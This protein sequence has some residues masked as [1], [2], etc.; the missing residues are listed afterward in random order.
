MRRVLQLAQVLLLIGAGFVGLYI[1]RSVELGRRGAD[2]V[3]ID[4]VNPDGELIGP[5][6]LSFDS[7]GNLFVGDAAGRIW[8]RDVSGRMVQHTKIDRLEPPV[9]VHAAGLAFDPAGNLYVAVYDFAGGSILRIDPALNVRFFASDIGSANYLVISQNGRHL[10]VS[11]FRR[12]GRLLRFP[13]AAPPP[14]K[15][16]LIVEGF[17]YPNG[18]AFGKDENV[19]FAAETYSG[20]ITSMDL[21]RLRPQ[22]ETVLSLKG[23]FSLGS[24]DGLAFDPR[25][26]ERRF[27]YVAENIRGMV[28][29]VDLQTNPPAIVKR[30]RLETGEGRP[31]PA[32]MAIRDGYLYFTDLWACSPVRILLR[33]PEWHR[34]VYRFRVTDLSNLF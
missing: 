32:S 7:R 5:E 30:F 3:G 33:R 18:L 4:R 23:G 25:D 22:P 34:H 6:G 31:C 8:K 24:L 16:D 14:A 29:V 19:L 10:W 20:R 13:L 9:Q 17:E 21:R 1:Y 15:P 2:A 11:D 28:S 12:P 27:L 26:R